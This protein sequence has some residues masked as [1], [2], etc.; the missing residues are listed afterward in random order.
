MSSPV[1]ISVI[2]CCHNSEQRLPETL[3][4]LKM[5]RVSVPVEWEVIVVDNASTDRTGSVASTCWG[6]DAPAPLRVIR[7]D[8]PGLTNA[9]LAGVAAARHGVYSFIDDDNW[10]SPDWIER[11]SGIFTEHAAVAACGGPAVAAF[12]DTEPVWFHLVQESFAVG[13]QSAAPGYLPMGKAL[14]GAGLSIRAEAW[15]AVFDRLPELFL[16][17][18]K[19]GKLTAGEDH[20]LCFRLQLTGHRL[21]Y[22]ESLTL[23]HFMPKGRMCWE[24]VLRQAEGFGRSEVVLRIYRRLIDPSISIRRSWLVEFFATLNYS[25]K[26]LVRNSLK[27]APAF[28]SATEKRFLKGYLLELWSMKSRYGQLQRIIEKRFSMHKGS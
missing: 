11:L 23:V 19:G 20:E 16:S 8:R 5:Q 2:I 21:Y 3:R 18:R 15:R 12:E 24:V 22:D 10:V 1:N 13:R 9:R 6:T 27:S 4:H 7:E 17:G 14:R 28:R 26:L 25:F